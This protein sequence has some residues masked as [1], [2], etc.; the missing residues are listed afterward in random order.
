MIPQLYRYPSVVQSKIPPPQTCQKYAT[1]QRA[2]KT[3]TQD[4]DARTRLSPRFCSAPLPP[5]LLYRHLPTPPPPPPLISH[6]RLR[7][8]R[9]VRLLRHPRACPRPRTSLETPLPYLSQTHA[10]S[11]SSLRPSASTFPPS[12]HPLLR[13]AY[14]DFP[15]HPLADPLLLW[16][17]PRGR[18][19]PLTART[20]PGATRSQFGSELRPGPG[21]RPGFPHPP[22]A[23]RRGRLPVSARLARP[24]RLPHL[25]GRA[26]ARDRP[27]RR[28]PAPR[29]TLAASQGQQAARGVRN[30]LR[31]RGAEY[32]SA[33]FEQDLPG[34][35]HSVRL[36]VNGDLRVP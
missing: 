25:T 17:R 29:V 9:P 16:P 24:A 4:A 27:R 14:L 36:R 11:P 5:L 30:L 10:R 33:P 31:E 13:P 8:P 2:D 7:G 19:S 18:R 21:S 23:C 28:R 34:D 22:S 32:F 3:W 6:L 26:A 1:R 20:P 12:C 35:V 15:A